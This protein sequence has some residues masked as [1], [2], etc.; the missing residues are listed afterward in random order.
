MNVNLFLPAPDRTVKCVPTLTQ[1]HPYLLGGNNPQNVILLHLIK[2][3][4][5]CHIGQLSFSKSVYD[6]DCIEP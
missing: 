6:Y 1:L 4:T 3:P 5:I 2:S